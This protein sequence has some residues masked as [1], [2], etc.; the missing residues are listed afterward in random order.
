M[1]ILIFS[2]GHGDVSSLDRLA[3]REAS[4]DLVL[5]GGDFAALGTPESGLPYLER[6]AAHYD[7]VFSVIGNS[8]DP[9][10][11]ETLEE[12]DISVEASL[13]YFSGLMFTG[14]G[15]SSH[16]MNDTPNE[17]TDEELMSD[18]SMA[19]AVGDRPDAD[20][21]DPTD[22]ERDP[23]TGM[24]SVMAPSV[25]PEPWNNL[26]VIAHNPPKDTALDRITSGFH[27]GSPLIRDFIERRKPLLVVTGHI[28]ESFAVDTLGPTTLV[29]PGSLAEG[30]YAVA[31]IAGGAG[32]P[33]RVV[34]VS[35]K[36]L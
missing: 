21:P 31:E 3:E 35:L 19:D 2:D 17:R 27:V 1:K 26:V 5:Y 22:G 24:P 32:K 30:R 15:G 18:L 10:F 33:F 23:S 6:L 9:L 29:N 12:Y 25:S 4:A 11:R 36:T 7:K 34:D 13:S 28:H 20:Y 16:F 8:D 14:S